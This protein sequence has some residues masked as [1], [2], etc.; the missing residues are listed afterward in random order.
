MHITHTHKLEIM[1]KYDSVYVVYTYS[2]VEG[3]LRKVR[4]TYD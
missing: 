3:V 4:N 2:F 1:K